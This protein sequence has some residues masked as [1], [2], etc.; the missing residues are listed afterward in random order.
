MSWLGS[1]VHE[2]GYD[3]NYDISSSY[4][5]TTP[6]IDLSNNIKICL[7]QMIHQHK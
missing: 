1:G 2:I 6:N 3:L 4:K 5:A 7:I